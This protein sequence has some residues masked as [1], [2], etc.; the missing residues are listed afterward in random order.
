MKKH[1]AL[2]LTAAMLTSTLL[3]LPTAA[4]TTS[5]TVAETGDKAAPVPCALPDWYTLSGKGDKYTVTFNENSTWKYVYIQYPY[6]LDTY[7]YYRKKG[8]TKWTKTE[9]ADI[10]MKKGQ[11]VEICYGNA[12]EKS[13]ILTI[14]AKE[15]AMCEDNIT[16]TAVAGPFTYKMK[17]L[18]GYKVYYTLNGKKPTTKSKRLTS[19]GVKITKDCTLRV[20]ITKP[21]YVNQYLYYKID[22]DESNKYAEMSGLLNLA[23]TY[24]TRGAGLCKEDVS[25]HLYFTTDGTKPTESS[26]EVM[27]NIGS[28]GYPIWE[29][30]TVNFLYVEDNGSKHYFKQTYVVNGNV[31]NAL[32]AKMI[33]GLGGG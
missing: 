33:P 9:E 2:V 6:S 21:G 19:K 27:Y 26:K 20:L 18:K 25:G 16:T 17:N 1:L 3:A 15:R 24:N 5:A 23:G 32:S 10:P 13:D 8:S 31:G 29:T 7:I 22:I 12:T 11:T 28:T 30:T 4:K 14:T